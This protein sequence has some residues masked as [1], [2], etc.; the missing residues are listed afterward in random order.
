MESASGKLSDTTRSN[1]DSECEVSSA[2]AWQSVGC[3]LR[4]VGDEL[5][6]LRSSLHQRS[7]QHLPQQR[8][9]TEMTIFRNFPTMVRM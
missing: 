9:R 4:H 1:L 3:D 7:C 8:R 2:A 5:C 6:G